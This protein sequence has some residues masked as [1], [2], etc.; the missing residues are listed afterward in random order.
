VSFS[1]HTWLACGDDREKT[2]A[3]EWKNVTFT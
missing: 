1:G 3:E 2:V